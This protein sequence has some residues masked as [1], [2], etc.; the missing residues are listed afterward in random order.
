MYLSISKQQ[1]KLAATHM[2]VI[3]VFVRYNQQSSEGM[4]VLDLHGLWGM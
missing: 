4:R 3:A 1:C 2:H